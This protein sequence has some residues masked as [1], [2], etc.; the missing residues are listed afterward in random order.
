MT[1]LTG[2]TVT[3]GGAALTPLRSQVGGALMTARF[4]SD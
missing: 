4:A 2:G 3:A 1:E